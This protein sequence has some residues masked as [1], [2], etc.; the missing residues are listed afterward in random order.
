MSPHK[1][2]MRVTRKLE[3][4]SGRNGVE[5]LIRRRAHEHQAMAGLAY[6]IELVIDR[7]YFGKRLSEADHHATRHLPRTK[8]SELAQQFGE[9]HS[10]ACAMAIQ[11]QEDRFVFGPRIVQRFD[12]MNSIQEDSLGDHRQLNSGTTA[13]VFVQILI[14]DLP[15]L[16][17]RPVFSRGSYCPLGFRSVRR[18]LP[19]RAG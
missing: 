5:I 8:T 15:I 1:E 13:E 17:S 18:S 14:G 19:H 16:P 11:R 3:L 7:Q 4:H 9:S 12:R 2:A 6:K 10:L